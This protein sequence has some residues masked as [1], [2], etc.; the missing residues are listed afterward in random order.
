MEFRIRERVVVYKYVYTLD[1]LCIYV[2]MTI[3]LILYC[4]TGPV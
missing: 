4:K 3:M 2:Y 1:I